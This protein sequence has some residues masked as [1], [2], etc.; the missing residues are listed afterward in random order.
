[1]WEGFMAFGVSEKSQV[2]EAKDEEVQGMGKCPAYGPC[3]SEGTTQGRGK[4]KVNTYFN[5][6]V[7]LVCFYVAVINTM[8]K[9]NLGGKSAYF[10][11]TFMS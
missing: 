3:S 7:L 5:V 10:A 4:E 9:R 8:A 1:M 2:K 6:R 11:F